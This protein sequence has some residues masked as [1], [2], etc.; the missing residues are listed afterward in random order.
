MSDNTGH[1][2]RLKKRFAES[3]FKGFHGYEILEMML[4]YAIPQ[5]DTKPLAKLLLKTFG[6]LSQV[7]DAPV[8]E[9]AGV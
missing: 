9:L 7:L 4:F 5:K 1:R 6:S 2:Q 8:E 3:G